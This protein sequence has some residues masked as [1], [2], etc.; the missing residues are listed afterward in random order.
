MGAGMSLA[1]VMERRIFMNIRQ[2]F[3]FLVFLFF[4][5]LRLFTTYEAGGEISDEQRKDQQFLRV[6]SSLVSDLELI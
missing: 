6:A 1:P 3:I 2:G 5:G 4:F